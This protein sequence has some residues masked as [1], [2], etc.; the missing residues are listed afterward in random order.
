MNIEREKLR[1]DNEARLRQDALSAFREATHLLQ[2]PMIGMVSGI[3]ALEYARRRGWVTFGT[4]GILEFTWLG[5]T[6]VNALAQSGI[7]DQLK[8]AGKTA[9][10]LLLAAGV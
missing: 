10:P 6:M 2:N 5:S 1:Y 7:V 8:D 3:L 4:A 9:L